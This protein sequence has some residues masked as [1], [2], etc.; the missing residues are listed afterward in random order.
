MPYD[1]DT[2]DRP[3]DPYAPFNADVRRAQQRAERDASL[4]RWWP[5]YAVT[6]AV[7]LVVLVLLLAR[8]PGGA[9]PALL[10]ALSSS[11]AGMGVANTVRAERLRRFR[12]NPES[13]E[14]GR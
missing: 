12:R 6:G 2:G 10:G 3:D 4:L 1:W 11:A 9:A 14:L 7:G 5:V 8:H 13:G